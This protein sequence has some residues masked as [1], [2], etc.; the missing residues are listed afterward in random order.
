MKT[1]KPIRSFVFLF[2]F[3]VVAFSIA[4]FTKQNQTHA[5]NTEAT[6]CVFLTVMGQENSD[7][8]FVYNTPA[9]V[10]SSID[11]GLEWIAKAQQNNGG[12]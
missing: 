3:L 1:K 7:S 11:E 10:K 5:S 8:D 2:L 9:N 12:W 4:T 6:G